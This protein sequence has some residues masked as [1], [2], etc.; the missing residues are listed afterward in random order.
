MVTFLKGKHITS[1]KH[2]NSLLGKE[3]KITSQNDRQYWS[4]IRLNRALRSQRRKNYN[5]NNASSALVRIGN[6]YKISFTESFN[7]HND[8]LLQKLIVLLDLVETWAIKQEKRLILDFSEAYD[9]KIEGV[10]LLYARVHAIQ[11]QTNNTTIISVICSQNS[12]VNTILDKS[13]FYRLCGKRMSSSIKGNWVPMQSAVT[14]APIGSQEEL[15]AR[16]SLREAITFMGNCIQASNLDK[17]MS[18][19]M[20]AAITESVSNV[21]DHAYLE[22]N[23]NDEFD[24]A[25]LG[26]RWWFL[27]E[28]IGNQ[29]FAVIYDMG[30][31]IP[32]TL[33]KKGFFRI[34]EQYWKTNTDPEI[35]KAAMEY[36]RSRHRQDKRGKGLSDIKQ[37]VEMNPMGQL[38]IISG[39]GRYEYN[40]KTSAESVSDLPMQLRGTLIKWNVCLEPVQP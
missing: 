13:G 1:S 10:I 15:N 33:P 5:P 27:T 14:S 12:S 26:K 9:I 11:I 29:L 39:K 6:R 31:G 16:E 40:S 21:G 38:N 34:I 24:I 2:L 3:M 8:Q 25:L 22:I 4:R 20:Y 23:N 17:D 37:F 19:S 7:T 28:R 32:R 18:N 30:M 36:G 35:L